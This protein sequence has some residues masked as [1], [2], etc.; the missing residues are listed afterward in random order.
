VGFLQRLFALH[1]AKPD[2]RRVLGSGL[3]GGPRN[4]ERLGLLATATVGEGWV[5]WPVF[6]AEPLQPRCPGRLLQPLLAFNL[7]PDIMTL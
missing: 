5:D 7:F 2:E 6:Q 1:R 3:Q 4:G